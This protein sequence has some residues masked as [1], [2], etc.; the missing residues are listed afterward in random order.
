MNAPRKF[1]FETTFETAEPSGKSRPAKKE[2]VKTFTEEDLVKARDDGFA[3]GK[4]AG[5]KAAEELIE[6]DVA[7]TLARLTQQLGEL[8]KV[9][10]D[11]I[12]RHGREAIEAALAVIRKLFPN[13]AE[14]HGMAEIEAIIGE[15]LSRLRGEPR[16]VIRVADSLLDAVKERVE[17]LSTEAGFEG[18][19]VLLAQNDLQAGDVRVEWADGGAERDGGALWRE[20]DDVVARV[21][22]GA[23]P[24]AGGA[25]PI[26]PAGAALTEES[27]RPKAV[28]Q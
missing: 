18:K 19:V 17:A 26:E 11:A 10:T 13:L 9:Q 27:D 2:P 20:I 22:G 21:I 24:D 28:S 25:T 8:G 5:Q 23:R 12:E 14:T 1:L 15:C 7:Q 6:R 3:A 4:D 16:V